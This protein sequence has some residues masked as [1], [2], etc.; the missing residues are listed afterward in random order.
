MSDIKVKDLR[1]LSKQELENQ[2]VDLKE[3]LLKLRAKQQSVKAG[4]IKRVR[5]SVA[6][7][8]TILNVSQREAVREL[9]KSKKY[10]PKDLR[11]KKTRAIRRRLSE[12]EA[13]AKTVKA[14]KKASAFPKRKYAISA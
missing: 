10:T 13:N 5:K 12:E 7:T 11:A 14:Q 9:Y 6:R 8:L 3:N 2:L 1:G 4:E